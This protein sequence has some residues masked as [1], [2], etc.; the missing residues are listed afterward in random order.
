MAP[1]DTYIEY[2]RSVPLFS[3]LSKADL[4]E[5]ARHSTDL[6]FEDGHVLIEQG[7][8]NTSSMLIVLEGTAVVRRNG[9]KVA[10]LGAGDFAG[11]LAMLSRQPRNASIVASGK[12]R[13]LVLDRRELMAL[14]DDV[15]RITKNLLLAVV[16]RLGSVDSRS[17]Q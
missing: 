14:I 17:I 16:E 5:V 4:N 9:R 3:K 15:P 7:D 2:L 10:S 11:E 8:P 1:R 12:L 13:A 6:T